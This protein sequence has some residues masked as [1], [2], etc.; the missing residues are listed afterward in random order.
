[1]MERLRSATEPE[2]T[3][4]T[5]TLD[6]ARSGNL[7]PATRVFLRKIVEDHL[8]SKARSRGA[9]A[10]LAATAQRIRRFVADGLRPETDGLFLVAGRTVWDAVELKVPLRNF[11]HTGSTPFLSPLLDAW[12]RAPRAFAAILSER[13]A[14]VREHE[15]GRWTARYFREPMLPERDTGV[16]NRGSRDRFR[17]VNDEAV[18]AMIRD[19]A[20]R[21]RSATEPILVFGSGERCAALREELPRSAQTKLV[22]TEF[23]EATAQ[24]ALDRLVQATRQEEVWRFLAQR[25]EGHAIA[26]GPREVLER[27]GSVAQIYVDPYDPVPG[28]RCASCGTRYP[29]LKARCEFCTGDLEPV[30]ITA[31]VVLHA[32]SHSGVRLT[33][34]GPNARWLEDLGGMAA[35]LRRPQ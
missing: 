18:R 6:V 32:L 17:Q 26:L 10:S 30:S 16:D 19:V 4:V 9:Q 35:L 20:E 21:L 12:G 25:A 11:V 8:A 22:A 1:M 33:F 13:G 15:G 7:P 29:G 14:E 28:M 5:L 2:G 31:E 23:H 34:V 3:I 24:R 27:V